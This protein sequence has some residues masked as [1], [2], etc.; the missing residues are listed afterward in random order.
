MRRYW[1]AYCRGVISA[2]LELV[3]TG[4]KD[5]CMPNIGFLKKEDTDFI[6][7]EARRVGLRTL[8]VVFNNETRQGK[9]FKTYQRIMYESSAAEKARRI[10]RLLRKSL[11]SKED[12]RELGR[13]FGYSL[14]RI[15]EYL[16][17][18]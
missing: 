13:L 3:R 10:Q 2:Y 11:K 15:Q 9:R 7:K 8:L 16:K 17:Q 5:V 4:I 6:K 18:K 14:E 12:H 1:K